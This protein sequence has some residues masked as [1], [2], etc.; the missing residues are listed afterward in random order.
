LI[1]RHQVYNFI[2]KFLTQEN[3]I[4]IDTPY[5]TK[6]TPEG[7]RDYLVP[8]RVEAGKFYA[9][10]QSPQQYKQLLM[11]AGADYTARTN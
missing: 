9:L 10:A 6:S 3:F 4:E 1:F 2:R 5:M 8:A 7:A 11:A